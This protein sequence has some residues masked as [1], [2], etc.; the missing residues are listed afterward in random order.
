MT[1]VTSVGFVSREKMDVRIMCWTAIPYMI[2]QLLSQAP[3]GQSRPLIGEYTL[4]LHVQLLSVAMLR[5][6]NSFQEPQLVLAISAL[7]HSVAT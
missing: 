2:G 4:T 6:N 7:R 1:D 5:S 3:K